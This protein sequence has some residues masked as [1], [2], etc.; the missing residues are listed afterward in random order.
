M[1]FCD[2][3]MHFNTNVKAVAQI[4]L[5]PWRIP[6]GPEQGWDP[7]PGSTDPADIWELKL[8][9]LSSEN[10]LWLQLI[11]ALTGEKKTQMN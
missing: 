11:C 5:L 7:P 1:S 9:L 6:E 3:L 2:L 4:L 8:S 10:P